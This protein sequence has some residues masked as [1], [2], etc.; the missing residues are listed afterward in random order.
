MQKAF[1]QCYC[2]CCNERL[3]CY[4]IGGVKSVFKRSTDVGIWNKVFPRYFWTMRVFPFHVTGSC[5]KRNQ[6]LLSKLPLFPC[7]TFKRRSILALNCFSLCSGMICLS[8]RPSIGVTIYYHWQC[9]L[10]HVQDVLVFAAFSMWVAFRKKHSFSYSVYLPS[11]LPTYLPT[12]LPIPRLLVRPPAH[13]S[14][15]HLI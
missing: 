15:I 3:R 10:F 6:N 4:I 9:V 11:Y 5:L 8:K 12:Y 7:E 13:P 14:I 2:R 1:S